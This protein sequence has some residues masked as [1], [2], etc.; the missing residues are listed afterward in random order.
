MVP[1]LEE[2]VRTHR[3]DPI[4]TFDLDRTF[5]RSIVEACAGP[6]LLDLHNSIQPQTERY[7]RLYASS[8]IDRL[9][10]SV[11]EHKTIIE[12][13]SRG[14]GNTAELALQLNWENGAARLAQ[15]SPAGTLGDAPHPVS[16]AVGVEGERAGDQHA[17]SFGQFPWPG[18]GCCW[19]QGGV[20][21]LV[22]QAARPGL[23]SSRLEETRLSFC[24]CRQPN[25]ARC[26]LLVVGASSVA[27]RWDTPPTGLEPLRGWA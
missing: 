6:R 14:D 2:L 13:I 9:A 3:R 10:D 19:L 18:R 23:T 1:G 8:I 22:A 11:A 4:R 21:K 26:L 20:L 17:G 25:K 27:W 15:L 7:W 5:H 24:L 12:A 16:Q